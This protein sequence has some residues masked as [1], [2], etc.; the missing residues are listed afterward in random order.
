MAY[1][2]FLNE[3]YGDKLP[4]G[5]VFRLPTEAEWEY[6]V[7]ANPKGDVFAVNGSVFAN[8]TERYLSKFEKLL[9]KKRRPASIRIGN[10]GWSSN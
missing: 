4:A 10:D 8:W 5:Y 7:A 2:R 1:C 6:A 3:R 9:H